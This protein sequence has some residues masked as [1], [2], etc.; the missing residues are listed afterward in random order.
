MRPDG[1][2]TPEGRKN[3]VRKP[4]CIYRRT[5]LHVRFVASRKG[6]RRIYE[7]FEGTGP[8]G[9]IDAASGGNDDEDED[10]EDDRDDNNYGDCDNDDNN[11]KKRC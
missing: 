3:R 11:K 8:I 9:P 10:D 1:D 4:G 2:S 6:S 7:Q 5:A